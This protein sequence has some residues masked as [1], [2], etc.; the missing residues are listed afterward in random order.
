MTLFGTAVGAGI[1]FLPI[2]AGLAGIIVLVLVALVGIPTIYFAHKNIG[3]MMTEAEGNVD[4]TGA[5]N[6]F[7]GQRTGFWI[8][9][10]FFITLFLLLIV[11]SSGLNDDIG[12]F[13]VDTGFTSSNLSHTI[14]LSLSILVILLFV[15][16]VGE[17]VMLRFM[18]FITFLLVAMLLAV[19]TYL[20]PQW[21]R[22]F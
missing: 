15:I 8:N 19:S 1:L 5:V 13:M 20:I 18:G 21:N 10:V 11:Y 17:K 2:T 4:Y 7:L 22:F 9:A 14:F 6:E 12:Q 3:M 16:R